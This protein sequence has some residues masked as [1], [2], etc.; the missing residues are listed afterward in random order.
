MRSLPP[1]KLVLFFGLC[2]I[3]KADKI[4]SPYASPVSATPVETGLLLF[5]D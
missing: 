3:I 4:T 2:D 5:S 1:G